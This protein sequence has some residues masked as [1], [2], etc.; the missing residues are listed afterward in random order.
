MFNWLF[1]QVVVRQ[2]LRGR[3]HLE[4]EML[5]SVPLASPN[6][7]LSGRSVYILFHYD[8]LCH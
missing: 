3:V 8:N 5:I 4:P 7:N 6:E 1:L 2:A